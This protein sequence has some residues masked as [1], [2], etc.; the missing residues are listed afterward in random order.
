MFK[1]YLN[2]NIFKE[3]IQYESEY[4]F[5]FNNF[6]NFNIFNIIK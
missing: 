5:I 3:F 4:N 2:K 6:N 1:I